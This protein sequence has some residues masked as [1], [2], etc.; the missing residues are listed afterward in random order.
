MNLDLFRVVYGIDLF[1][2]YAIEQ[3]E[4]L[5]MSES[6]HCCRI[7]ILGL[8]YENIFGIMWPQKPCLNGI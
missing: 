7:N 5:N 3:Q 1:L 4:S 6:L 2:P 8:K